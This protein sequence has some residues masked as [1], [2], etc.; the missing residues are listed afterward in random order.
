MVDWGLSINCEQLWCGGGSRKCCGMLHGRGLG[1]RGTRY[2]SVILQK[3]KHK[4]NLTGS[5][6]IQNYNI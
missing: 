1:G 5:L 6:C 3:I 4:I 2:C